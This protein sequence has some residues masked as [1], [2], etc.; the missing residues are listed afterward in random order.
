MQSSEFDKL[1]AGENSV[2]WSP[3]HLTDTMNE[4]QINDH[5]NK[6]HAP[7]NVYNGN[8]IADVHVGYAETHPTEEHIKQQLVEYVRAHQIEIPND[9]KQ[10][11]RKFVD[12]LRKKG[13]SERQIRRAVERE[14]NIKVV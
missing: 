6:I 14:F 12:K 7:A 5:L 10:K 4:E 3:M 8:D 9:V 1:I 2:K 11:V 13:D